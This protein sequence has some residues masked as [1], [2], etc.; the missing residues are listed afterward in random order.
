M[1][2]KRTT[3]GG[4]HTGTTGETQRSGHVHTSH[5]NDVNMTSHSLAANAV[6][7]GPVPYVPVVSIVT[8]QGE[9]ICM[10]VLHTQHIHLHCEWIPLGPSVGGV[11]RAAQ[12][13]GHIFR[14]HPPSS[15]KRC[16]DRGAASVQGSEG[17]LLVRTNW[18]GLLDRRPVERRGRVG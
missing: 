5:V 15:R 7:T 8:S 10:P 3:G 13:T 11:L 2:D 9:A 1:V 12:I 17:D 18:S 14:S 16:C 6:S 4:A